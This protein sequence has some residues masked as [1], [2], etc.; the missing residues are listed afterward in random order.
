[1]QQLEKQYHINCAPGDVGRYCILP[2][3]PGRCASI[4]AL[5]D[6][7]SLVSQ[8]REYTV[9]TGTLLWKRSLYAPPVSAVPPLLSPWRN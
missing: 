3:D 9:Y 6:D 5:F 4:A 2:G 7:A 8:N 1:M